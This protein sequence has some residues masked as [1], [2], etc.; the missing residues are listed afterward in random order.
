[1]RPSS[2]DTSE[3]ACVKRQML[4]VKRRVAACGDRH[5]GSQPCGWG[6]AIPDPTGLGRGGPALTYIPRA[7]LTAWLAQQV[8]NSADRFLTNRH[9]DRPAGIDTV[10]PTAEAVGGT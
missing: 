8:E 4:S 6:R 1:M 7:A 2:A 9:G 5:D 10:H 3:P